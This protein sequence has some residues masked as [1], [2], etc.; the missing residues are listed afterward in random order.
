MSMDFIGTYKKRKSPEILI[1]TWS[2]GLYWT[3]LACC[4]VEAGGVEP[5]GVI[6]RTPQKSNNYK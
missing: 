5:K 1:R 2:F 4:L 6:F 3:I